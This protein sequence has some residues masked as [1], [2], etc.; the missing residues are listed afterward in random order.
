MGK[1]AMNLVLIIFLIQN[2]RM[3]TSIFSNG[4]VNLILTLDRQRIG[5]HIRLSTMRHV[6]VPKKDGRIFQILKLC[7]ASCL[8]LLISGITAAVKSEYRRKNVNLALCNTKSNSTLTCYED[9][10]TAMNG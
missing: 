6:M 1:L 3:N 9:Q 5:K 2:L 4:L 7:F 10:L 8:E